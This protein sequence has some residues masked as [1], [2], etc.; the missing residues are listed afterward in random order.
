MKPLPTRPTNTKKTDRKRLKKNKQLLQKASTTPRHHPE[1]P[2]RG[3]Y[4]VIRLY[5]GPGDA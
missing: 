2:L 5:L 3:K 4:S 1:F